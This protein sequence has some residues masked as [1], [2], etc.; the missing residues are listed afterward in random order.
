MPVE[1]QD[2]HLVD[3][4]VSSLVPVRFARAMGADIVIAVDIYCQGSGSQGLGAPAILLR[5]SR[6][7]SCAAAQLE[8][9]EADLLISPSV[10]VPG[11]S[12]KDEQDQ[13]IDEGYTAA[14]AALK[15][16]GFQTAPMKAAAVSAS[17]L[18]AR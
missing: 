8:T 15:R 17:P 14:V 3:G 10:K 11:L 13:A 4:G 1:Y 6:A 7:Q 12:A 9:A 16:G 2:G 5:V 18:P